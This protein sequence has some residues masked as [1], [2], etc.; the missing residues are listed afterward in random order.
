MNDLQL[1]TRREVAELVRVDQSTIWRWTKRGEF[2]AP[3]PVGRNSTRWRATDIEEWLAKAGLRNLSQL[4]AM[5]R[6]AVQQKT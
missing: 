3:F 5:S 1:L 4:D 2:P 6:S